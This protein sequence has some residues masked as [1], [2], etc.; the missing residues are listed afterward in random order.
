VPVIVLAACRFTPGVSG[1]ER[2]GS[3]VDRDG[4]DPESD[5]DSDGVPDLTDNCPDVPNADQA[6]E[7][8]DGVGNACDNCPHVANPGQ[9]NT[10]EVENGQDADE[11]G[12]ACDPRPAET[13]ERIALFL[14]FDSPSEIADWQSAGT[15]AAFA[16]AGGQLEQTGATD[17]AILWKNGLGLAD[18][19]ITTEVT[20]K[21]I[22]SN[23]QFRGAAVMTRFVRTSTFGHGVGCGEMRDSLY[24]NNTP[25]FNLVR[26]DAGAFSNTPFGLGNAAVHAGHTATYTVHRVTGNDYECAVLPGATYTGTRGLSEGGGTGINLAVWGAQISFKYL[27]AIVTE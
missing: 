26:F 1:V 17:L 16:V 12:D 2:D 7:D 19:W 11:V 9:E 5:R 22:Y 14:P 18:A 21:S 4:V 25:F 10:G 3:L 24:A 8:R 23:R 13:G 20:Y 27:V 6:D 15:N